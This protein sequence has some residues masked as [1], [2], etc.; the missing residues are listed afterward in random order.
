[1][2]GLVCAPL[3]LLYL[4]VYWDVVNNVYESGLCENHKF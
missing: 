1:M 2:Q 3:Q 4:G